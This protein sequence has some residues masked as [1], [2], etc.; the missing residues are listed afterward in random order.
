[1][2]QDHRDVLHFLSRTALCKPALLV[3]CLIH[4]EE[5]DGEISIISLLKCWALSRDDRSKSVIRLR[6]NEL[7]VLEICNSEKT[8][9]NFDAKTKIVHFFVRSFISDK[10]SKLKSCSISSSID[11]SFN[12]LLVKTI[13]M[14]CKVLHYKIFYTKWQ[15]Q[16]GV[17]TTQWTW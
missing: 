7:Q 3:H 1:M 12:L 6:N 5:L 11:S 8:R 16:R 15:W 17:F 2:L 13:M 4:L 14:S 9:S 10:L